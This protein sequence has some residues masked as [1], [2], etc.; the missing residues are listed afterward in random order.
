MADI[1]EGID[2]YILDKGNIRKAK[3]VQEYTEFSKDANN[4]RVDLTLIDIKGVKVEVSTVFLMI[5]HRVIHSPGCRAVLF[6]TMVFGGDYDGYQKRYTTYGDAK[7]GHWK[8]VDAIR[9]SKDPAD[10]DS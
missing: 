6:E 2:F 9:N 7:I 5:D 10:D 1:P 8:I 3:S 4:R